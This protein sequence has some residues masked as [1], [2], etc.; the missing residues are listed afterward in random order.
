MKTLI[1]GGNGDIAQA[2]KKAIV[3]KY[4]S[5]IIYNPSKEEMNVSNYFSVENFLFQKDI[6]I[7]INN[8]GVIYPDEVETSNVIDW[9][10][11]IQV[12]LLGTYFTTRIA[13]EHGCKTVIN[14]ASTSGLKGRAGWSAYCAS[15]AGVIN[16]TQSL[17]EEGINA[18][19]LIVRRTNTKMRNRLFPNEDKDTLDT[20]EEV[21]EKIIGLL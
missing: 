20:P 15:K 6:D 7:V 4:P 8:A 18:H 21:A 19:C 12:N 1:T 13:L 5:C 10:K 2:I 17:Q 14:L 11:T 3:K 9:V 16:F